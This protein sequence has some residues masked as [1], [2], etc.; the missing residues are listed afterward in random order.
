MPN[1]LWL[2][3]CERFFNSVYII[4]LYFVQFERNTE[5]RLNISDRIRKNMPA[6]DSK[7]AA[8]ASSVLTTPLAGT[9]PPPPRQQVTVTYPA[10]GHVNT[11][12]SSKPKQLN[13]HSQ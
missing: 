3:P 9:I 1:C 5:T 2:V 4:K 8:V 13:K 11:E 7:T 6:V 10:G 12:D